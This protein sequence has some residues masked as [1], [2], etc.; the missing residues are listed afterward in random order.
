MAKLV[1]NVILR[2][3]STGRPVALFA[4]DEVPVWAE[5]GA[6]LLDATEAPKRTAS[7][8]ASKAE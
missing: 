6:H 8:A 5:V 1:G 2:D 7:K 4:G 3:P